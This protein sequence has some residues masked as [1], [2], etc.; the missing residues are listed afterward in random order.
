MSKQPSKKLSSLQISQNEF[1]ARMIRALW[2]DENVIVSPF[3]IFVALSMCLVGADG[4]T[5]TE[6]AKALCVECEKK[7]FTE[8]KNGALKSYLD[9]ISDKVLKSNPLLSV[10]NKMF[11]SKSCHVK[12][13]FK[14]DMV[15]LFDSEIQSDCDFAGNRDKVAKEINEWVSEATKNKIQDIM[16]PSLIDPL[17]VLI[18]VNAIHF[19][20]N[21]ADQFNKNQT[22]EDHEFHTVDGEELTCNMMVK[23][24]EQC[25]N[26]MYGSDGNYHYL[27]IP[28]TNEDYAMIFAAPDDDVTLDED[29]EKQFSEWFCD[30]LQNVKKNFTF[31]KQNLS[32]I[33]IPR[34]EVNQ[35]VELS[36]VLQTDFNM[37][38]AFSDS[39]ANFNPMT[40]VLIKIDKIIHKAFI[41]V[42]EEGTEA[43]AATVVTMKKRSK[44]SGQKLPEFVLDRPFG[45][46]LIHL[47]THSVLFCG[48]IVKP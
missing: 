32:T 29:S 30:R 27:Q 43:A 42:D 18:L 45:Y 38:T 19:L 40:D 36:K 13:A 8:W 31:K 20:G 47:P 12:D 22:E 21:W 41:R 35:G 23:G 26:K 46:A 15:T 4:D 17:T 39:K 25:K 37:T 9:E 3:S 10:A 6:I 2:N 16:N 33:K 24:A 1:S 34:F 5:F 48:R 14:K 7:D 28:Y 11:A 44:V